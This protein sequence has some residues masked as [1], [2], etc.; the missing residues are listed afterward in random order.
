M[1]LLMTYT[2]HS[3]LQV[4]TAPSPIS[5]FYKSPAHA[6]SSQAS[7]DASWQQWRS[8]SFTHSGPLVTAA[9][10]ELNSF[11]YIAISSESPL[12]SSTELPTLNSQLITELNRSKSKLYYDRRSAGQSAL[13][14]STRLG[15]RPEFYYCLTVA[16]LLMW[17]AISDERTGLLLTSAAG[18]RQRSHSWYRVPTI[19][20]YLRF[21]TP[22]TWRSRSPYIQ[23]HHPG[24]GW[25]NYTPR[26]WVHFVD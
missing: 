24:T 20:Y 18:P 2:H 26:H 1:D 17:G 9:R 21:E 5:T 13:V 23:I 11:N 10:A 8:F 4:I 7:L 22:K 12:L 6:K 3:K 25:P 14:S 16:G 19:F 15:L